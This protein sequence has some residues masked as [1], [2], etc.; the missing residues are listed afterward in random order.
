MLCDYV[1]TLE[2]AKNCARFPD[3]VAR[4]YGAVDRPGLA[5]RRGRAADMQSGYDFP[6][7]A[8]LAQG[9]EG[10]LV[11]GR[12]GSYTH[13]GLAAGKSMGNMMAIGQAAGAA[14]ARGL[15]PVRRA[16]RPALCR[17]P[18]RAGRPG[19]VPLKKERQEGVFHAHCGYA[20]PGAGGV[21]GL[22]PE[23]PRL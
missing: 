4:R 15:R 20:G 7:R 19:R 3:V 23:T 5:R 10:L 12:C 2:D 14:A 21:H 6:Y 22:Q 9:L 11:A 1:V 13:M 16:A 8:L 18:R 17:G